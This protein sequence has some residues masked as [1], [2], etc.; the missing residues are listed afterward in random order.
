ML[1]YLKI[2]FRRPDIYCIPTNGHGKIYKGHVCLFRAVAVH[3]YG[4]AE[5]EIKAAKLFSSFLYESGHEAINFRGVSVDPLVF[6]ENAIKLNIFRY[7]SDIGDGDFIGEPA[8]I[9]ILMY[10]NSI[11]LWRYNNHICYV[12]DIKTFFKRFRCSNCDTFIKRADSFNR[13]VKHC[14]DSI[15]FVY[16]KIVYTLCESLFNKIDG[17]GIKYEEDQNLFKS[18][19]I[20]VLNQFTFQLRS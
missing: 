10:Q 15:Q 13:H 9:G 12:D 6:V 1:L 2:L 14:T 18:L 20:F 19:T 5:L 16:P 17:F 4:S 7:D 8:R 3:L 11:N